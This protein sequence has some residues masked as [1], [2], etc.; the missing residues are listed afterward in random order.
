MECY[1]GKSF[2]NT[3]L[4]HLTKLELMHN[5]PIPKLK[6]IPK[7]FKNTPLLQEA[8]F[9]DLYDSHL[10][11]ILDTCPMLN[12]IGVLTII[13]DCE[14]KGTIRVHL[15]TLPRLES[16]HISI[17]EEYSKGIRI[18]GEKDTHD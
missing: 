15:D 13:E 8:Y 9:R 6:R 18:V 1:L 17:F 14:F 2:F 5:K 4:P 11:M 16:I 3:K 7:F 10:Q 12:K